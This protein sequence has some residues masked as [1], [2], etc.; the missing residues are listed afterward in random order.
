MGARISSHSFATHLS[1]MLSVKM[2]QPSITLVK[3]YSFLIIFDSSNTDRKFQFTISSSRRMSWET[4]HSVNL[5]C[6]RVVWNNEFDSNFHSKMISFD[7]LVSWWTVTVR[8]TVWN[9]HFFLYLHLLISINR[10]FVIL[11][12][13]PEFLYTTVKFSKQGCSFQEIEKYVSVYI[14]SWKKLSS[15]CNIVSSIFYF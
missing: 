3:F 12:P 14:K 9:L 13:E 4:S 11:S 2:C 1:T 10:L 15:V 6:R 8:L 7:F 5:Y